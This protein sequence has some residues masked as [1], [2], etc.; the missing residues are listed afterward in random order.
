VKDIF[1]VNPMLFSG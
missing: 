1:I